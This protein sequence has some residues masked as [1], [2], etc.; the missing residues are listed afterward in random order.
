MKGPETF[1]VKS[2]TF[3][4]ELAQ[5]HSQAL[6]ELCS[7]QGPCSPISDQSHAHCGPQCEELYRELS[8]K[9]RKLTSVPYKVSP[10]HTNLH[11][12]SNS[13]QKTR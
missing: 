10:K 5:I 9:I 13:Q 8:T 1:P 11:N 7:L 12:V 3:L 6:G 2:G 4:E